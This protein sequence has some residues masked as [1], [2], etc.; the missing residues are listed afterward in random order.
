MER[1]LLLV[2]SCCV[3]H[4]AFAISLGCVLSAIL[5]SFD[6]DSSRDLDLT[7]YAYYVYECDPAVDSHLGLSHL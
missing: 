2:F 5:R 1:W 4:T 3:W 6:S 7:V